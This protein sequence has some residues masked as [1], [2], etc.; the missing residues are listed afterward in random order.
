MNGRIKIIRYVMIVILILLIGRAAY[1]QIGIGEYYYQLSE[2]NRISNRPISSPRGK[3]IDRNG[4]VLV[5]N[6]LSHNL[7]ILP[8]EIPPDITPTEVIKQ[9]CQYTDL[10]YDRLVEN[11][12]S[13]EGERFTSA[14]LL[15]RNISSE[16]MIQIEENSENLPG[17]L[18][19]ESLIR[20]Y[21]DGELASHILGYVGKI[22]E[23]RL[24]ELN[25]RGYK[26][27]GNDIV[28]KTGLESEYE[29]FLKGE[30]GIEQIEVNNKGRK[31]QTLGIEDPEP[32][33]DLILNIDK[34]IQE[35]TDNLLQDSFY[36]LRQLAAADDELNP[37]TG[38]GAM[39]MDVN[40]GKV[41]AMSS[42]PTFDLNRFGE[43]ITEDQYQEMSSDPL[44]PQLNRL[45]MSLVPPGSIFKLVT[46]TAAIEYLD[47]DGET[48]FE[49]EDGKFRIPDWERPFRNWNPRGEGKL[50]FTKGI[51][52]SNNIVF[53]ELG[54]RLYEEYRGSKLVETAREYGMGEETGIDL[55]SERSGTVPDGEWKKE[56]FGEGWY[57]GDSVNLSIGQG[58][59]LTTPLQLITLV[60][61]IANEGELYEP[62][63]VDKVIN[64]E[65][66]VIED[67]QPKIKRE[68][69]FSNE[70]YKIL[71][72][73]MKNVTGE[74][75]GTASDVFKDFPVR[76]AGK[77][78]TA[79]SGRTNHGWFVGFAPADNPEIAVLVFLENGNSSSYT[80]P[81]AAD[82]F[83]YYFANDRKNDFMK[84][85]L[86][87]EEDE[88]EEDEPNSFFEFLRSVFS[89]DRQDF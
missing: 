34:D 70:T 76:V 67:F 14:V 32:G 39:V 82:I 19:N 63:L 9:I 43:G 83:S 10:D 38:A 46:G 49:D 4:E 42:M 16:T 57:P 7:Y 61:A 74:D 6:K 50:D 48:E 75:Y 21:V 8:N 41:L 47:I 78:G 71:R 15:R 29:S 17:V 65:G 31:V 55:P 27:T 13:N 25:E 79:E 59:L 56:K 66:E 54:Y 2:N 69:P 23:S 88:F 20:D 52:R 37:P 60:N 24:L 1:L 36:Q 51:A 89:E 28:G 58:G 68:L 40:S 77:T 35:N 84:Y 5:S 86:T 30:D 11:F 53:Y 3:I 64:N 33:N 44:M 85:D 26:Y 87:E 12:N 45:T 80:L 22:S 62:Y 73:G 72:E 81:I 18:V